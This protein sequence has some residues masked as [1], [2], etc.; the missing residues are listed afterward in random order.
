MEELEIDG[1]DEDDDLDAQLEAQFVSEMRSQGGGSLA[2]GIL[3]DPDIE[4]NPL[5]FLKVSEAYW[6]V[7]PRYFFSLTRRCVYFR[8]WKTLRRWLGHVSKGVKRRC[9]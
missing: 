2:R 1:L 6:T 7:G 9:Q 3:S 4:G 8:S 5:P